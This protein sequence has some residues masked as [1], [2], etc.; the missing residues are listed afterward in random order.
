VLEVLLAVVGLGDGETVGE[1]E[2]EGD[3]DG[4][5]DAVSLGLGEGEL[6][7]V[8]VGEGSVGVG[9][10]SV[11]VGD[12][13]V[14][15]GEGSVGVGDGSL[16]EG[17]LSVGVSVDIRHV[18]ATP[19]GAAVR[20]S[21]RFVGREGKLYLFEVWAEDPGGEIGRGRHARAIVSNERLMDGARRRG[22]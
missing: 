1:I 4:D 7:S 9:E 10:G 19:L 22:G 15:V 14:G 16:G 13:S 6:V 11:G 21:A 20:A 18:A 5:G 17:E 8:G 12:G 3:T 2:G